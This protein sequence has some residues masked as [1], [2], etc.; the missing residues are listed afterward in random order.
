MHG[1]PVLLKVST[2]LTVRST[3]WMSSQRAILVSDHGKENSNTCLWLDS[4]FMGEQSWT[5]VL[6]DSSTILNWSTATVT[7]R[8]IF[9]VAISRLLL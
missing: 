6:N 3:C 5:Y 4:S 2:M 9:A 1:S 8:Y 7:V